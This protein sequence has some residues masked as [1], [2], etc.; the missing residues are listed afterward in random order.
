MRIG[1]NSQFVRAV[2]VA[3]KAKDPHEEIAALLED[4]IFFSGKR[5]KRF[6]ILYYGLR[7]SL[8][9]LSACAAAKGLD[10]LEKLAPALSLIVAIGTTIDTWLK[11]GIQYKVH[12]TYNDRFRALRAD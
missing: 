3:P 9:V 11:P 10:P 1:T 6:G 7:A 4:S 5:A 8:I 12:Y 2:P